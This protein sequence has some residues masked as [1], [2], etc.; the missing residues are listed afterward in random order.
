MRTL[1]K[2]Y[3]LVWQLSFA[4]N[5]KFSQCGKCFNTLTG[6]EIKRTYCGG[7][8]GFCIKGKFHTLKKLRPFLVKFELEYCPF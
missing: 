3:P 8:N 5:Y 6:K 1:S 2:D 7:S 4:E